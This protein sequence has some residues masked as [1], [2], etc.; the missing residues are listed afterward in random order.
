ME[1]FDNNLN[2]NLQAIKDVNTDNFMTDVIEASKTK[3]IIVDFWAPW[4]EP[5]KQLTPIL[6]AA[7]LKNK[8]KLVLAKINIDENQ[9]IAAQLKIQSIPT[10]YAFYEG[11]VVDGFQ[12]AQSNSE[13]L[14][15]IKKIIDLVGPGEDVASLLS[16]ISVCVEDRKW[17]EAM[18]IAQN[19]L[20]IDPE[21]NIAFAGLIRSMIGLHQFNDVREMSKAISEQIRISKPVSDALS[22]LD[23]SEK[24]YKAKENIQDLEKKLKQKPND[25]DLILEMA[26]AL[27][28]N[29]SISDC[30]D[31]LLSSIENDRE[32]NDQAARKQL[33]EFFNTTGFQA[34]ETILAR[35]K[36]ASL[37]FS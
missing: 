37:L 20:A 3:P 8:D 28:G 31:L 19:I 2:H 34:K 12:G 27:Y 15:F 22:I 25:L 10:V 29:G 16:M 9:D 7:V 36:L 18:E 4:C 5:C 23:S 14:A 35:R 21:N 24:A 13:I 26:I 33:I 11:K 30:F 32:W 17:V 1:A 6:E